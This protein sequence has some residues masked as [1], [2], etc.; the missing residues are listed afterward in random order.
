MLFI[1]TIL[2]SACKNDKKID[3]AALQPAPEIAVEDFFKNSEK[4]TFRLS[5]NG[6]FIAYL[7]PYENRMNIHVRKF[8][9]DSG[10]K[11]NKCS[12]S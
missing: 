4:R 3:I 11:S 9:S 1:L 7:A 2:L 5:P 6:E 12:R 8:D 10:Y